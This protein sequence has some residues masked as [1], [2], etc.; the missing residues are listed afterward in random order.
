MD[1]DRGPVP[2]CYGS[3]GK[4]RWKEAAHSEA[5]GHIPVQ[6]LLFIASDPALRGSGSDLSN[7]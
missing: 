3:L 1:G 7:R 4:T 6:K 2:R 5:W